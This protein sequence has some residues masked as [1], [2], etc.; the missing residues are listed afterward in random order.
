MAASPQNIV[1][2]FCNIINFGKLNDE[3]IL[4]TFSLKVEKNMIATGATNIKVI[5]TSTSK[6]VVS[7][8]LMRTIRAAEE[9]K[10]KGNLKF[11]SNINDFMDA[12]K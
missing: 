12:L 4:M 5:D 11:Y 8:K 2:K 7:K 6:P 1:P 10:K 9:E 3:S